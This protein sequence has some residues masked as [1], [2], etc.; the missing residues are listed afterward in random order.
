M[1]DVSPFGKLVLL[2]L[3]LV[4]LLT[5]CTPEDPY[6]DIVVPEDRQIVFTQERLESVLNLAFGE[7]ERLFHQTERRGDSRF[8]YLATREMFDELDSVF[9]LQNLVLNLEH[10]APTIAGGVFEYSSSISL[11][12]TV[13]QFKFHRDVALV[14]WP[15]TEQFNSKIFQMEVP[16]GFPCRIYRK[17]NDHEIEYVVLT[18]KSP[19]N[20]KF[21][22]EFGSCIAAALY[23]AYGVSNLEKVFREFTGPSGY[24]T[25]YY[26]FMYGLNSRSSIRPGM[27][28][29]EV[30]LA[31][32][33]QL[34]ILQQELDLEIKKQ[35]SEA[36]DE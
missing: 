31:L 8:I 11:V 28:R 6:K 34:K 23:A 26:W 15:G 20:I 22:N 17:S 33:K 27:T 21:D 35:I 24:I 12:K 29:D 7:N 36:K 2:A 3:L 25:D 30:R 19:Y 16:V 1:G 4:L 9:H 10:E 18:L 32:Q 13:K 14:F 5:G